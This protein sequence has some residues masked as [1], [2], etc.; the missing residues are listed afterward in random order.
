MGLA[1]IP[2]FHNTIVITC[3][4]NVAVFQMFDAVNRFIV[5]VLQTALQLAL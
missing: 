4:Y 5:S 3:R 2:H 1:Q